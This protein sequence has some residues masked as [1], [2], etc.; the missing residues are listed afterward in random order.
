M[1]HPARQ[2][3]SRRGSREPLLRLASAF[4]LIFALGACDTLDRA[5]QV[6]V[7]SDIPSNV[8]DDPQT[9][10]VL[11]AGVVADFDCALGSYIVNGGMLGNEL[12]DG[13]FTVNRWPVDSRSLGPADSRYATFNCENLGVYT[14]LATA[15]WSADTTTAKL[16]GWTDQQVSNRSRLIATAAAYAG[17]AHVLFGEGFCSAAFDL[18][19]ELTPQQVFQRAEERFTRAIAAAQAASAAAPTGTAGAAERARADT[20]LNMA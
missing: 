13:T 3:S 18:G 6:E 4:L 8:L 12:V 7:P 19:P 14:P 1:K 11:V 16:E 15:R 5:L 10:P 17:Y 20:L 2:G 9:A